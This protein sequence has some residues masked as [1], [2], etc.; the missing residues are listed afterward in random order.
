MRDPPLTDKSIYNIIGK[1]RPTLK[2]LGMNRPD[3]VLSSNLLRAEQTAH[4]LYPKR[5]VYIAPYIA[6]LG[7]GLD[8]VSHQPENQRKA[9]FKQQKAFADLAVQ[10]SW[11][12]R[13][14]YIPKNDKPV[15][16]MFVLGPRDTAAPRLRAVQKTWNTI[17]VPN[18]N[19]FIFWLAK[20]LPILLHMN[21]VDK[22][23]KNI[24]I[25]VA[26][27][28]HFMMKNIENDR[29]KDKPNNVGM[30]ELN[31]CLRKTSEVHHGRQV[32]VRKLFPIVQSTCGCESIPT[33]KGTMPYANVREPSQNCNGVVY[34]GFPVPC[35]NSPNKG[36][37]VKK[38]EKAGGKKNCPF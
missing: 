1:A 5:T 25:A 2:K 12:D 36:A 10:K 20:A 30:V 37:C 7:T 3:V 8:N 24:L 38:F 31:F 27:H 23:K 13:F 15:S 18:Y 28:S 9:F 29:P 17:T 19:K 4:Y 32:W 34:H 33:L 14:R 6:E 21:G 16:Y 11:F 22:N 35:S 26:G